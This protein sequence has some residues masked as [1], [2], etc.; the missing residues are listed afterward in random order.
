MLRG[1]G[2]F[3]YKGTLK[4]IYPNPPDRKP[5]FVSEEKTQVN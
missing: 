1:L 4:N 3:G 2:G 5:D